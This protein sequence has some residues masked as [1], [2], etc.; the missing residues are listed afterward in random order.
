M[1]KNYKV[2]RSTYEDFL[3]QNNGQSSNFDISRKIQRG[4]Y[5]NEHNEG[6]C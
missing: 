3:E 1:K 2:G 6:R 5:F 4:P